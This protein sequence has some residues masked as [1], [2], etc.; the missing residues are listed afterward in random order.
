MRYGGSGGDV[1]RMGW[2]ACSSSKVHRALNLF[3]SLRDTFS[4]AASTDLHAAATVSSRKQSSTAPLSS[5]SASTVT[6]AS[7]ATT[8]TAATAT[9]ATTK[10][11]SP[12]PTPMSGSLFL[13]GEAQVDPDGGADLLRINHTYTESELQGMSKTEVARQLRVVMAISRRLLHKNQKLSAEAQRR[14]GESAA[15]LTELKPPQHHSNPSSS[16]N[17]NQI[18]SQTTATAESVQSKPCDLSSPLRPSGGM[19]ANQPSEAAAA[20]SA[21]SVEEMKSQIA[22]L[23][24]EVRRLGRHKE[25][26]TA[27]LY[28][29]EKDIRKLKAAK[30]VPLADP[31]PAMSS[32][33]SLPPPDCTHENPRRLSSE[34]CVVL[35]DQIKTLEYRLAESEARAEKATQL[36]LHALLSHDGCGGVNEDLGSTASLV[37]EQ[38]QQLLQLL[39]KQ[40]ITDAVAYQTERARLSELLYLMAGG[41]L[42]FAPRL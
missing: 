8:I 38:V 39:Q 40:L 37:D 3:E 14:N 21:P 13:E 29:A 41:G 20:E 4:D 42:S 12:F 30:T 31:P 18:L 23:E 11:T 2:S 7:A 22:A 6:A 15:S 35:K 28:K 19:E 33:P 16:L 25:R 26:L 32:P 10:G 36:Q 9:A 27:R 24:A 5:N 34:L 1:E 17:S